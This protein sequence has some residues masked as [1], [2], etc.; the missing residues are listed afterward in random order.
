M[1]LVWPNLDDDDFSEKEEGT[2]HEALPVE[3][4]I[5]YGANAW[6][7]LRRFESRCNTADFRKW[8]QK[9]NVNFNE[10]DV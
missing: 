1:A 6:F 10:N 3:K 4:G 5:K 7:H 2:W 8:K 9:H